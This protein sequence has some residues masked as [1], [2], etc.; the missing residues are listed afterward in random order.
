LL[1]L[2]QVLVRSVGAGQQYSPANPPAPL[3]TAYYGIAEGKIAQSLTLTT[4]QVKADISADPSE[5]LFGVATARGLSPDELYA[6]EIVALQAASDTMTTTGQWTQAQD[7]ATMRYW[8]ARGAKALGADLT[9]W[10]L[11]R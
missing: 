9:D 3:T 11:H 4:A 7:D 1:V 5:G 10:F 2:W 8:R 6:S